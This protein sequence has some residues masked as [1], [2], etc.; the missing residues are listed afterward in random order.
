M[1]NETKIDLQGNTWILSDPMSPDE[2]WIKENDK[3]FPKAYQD[4][5]EWDVDG[6]E[7]GTYGYFTPEFSIDD[8][9]PFCGD[10]LSLDIFDTD[11]DNATISASCEHHNDGTIFFPPHDVPYEQYE[12]EGDTWVPYGDTYV[13]L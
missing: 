5:G 10:K 11:G 13:K 1:S 6:D 7:D 2:G 12:D 8:N 3:S 4:G 9:C